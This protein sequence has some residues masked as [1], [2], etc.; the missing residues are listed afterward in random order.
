MDDKKQVLTIK[1]VAEYLGVHPSTIYKYAQTGQIP[2]FKI[3]SD[4]RFKKELIDQWIRETKLV[5]WEDHPAPSAAPTEI[6]KAKEHTSGDIAVIG[7]ACHYP[8]AHN[9]KELWENILAKRVQFRRM[10]DQRL[11]LSEY[12]DENPKT[13]DKMYATKAALLDDFDFDWAKYR[14]PRKTFESTDIVHWLALEVAFKAFEDAGYKLNEIPLENTGVI[15]GNTLTGEQTRSMTLRL[16][17]PYVKKVLDT[18]LESSGMASAD[19]EKLAE[20]MEK[21]FKSAFYPITEDTLAGGLANTIAGRI[22]NYLNFKGGGYLVD[23]ACSS[24][25][26]SV[27]TAANALKNGD[28][29]LALAGGVDIS[30]DPFELVGFS[31]AGA[32]AKDQMKVYDKNAS[33]FIPGEG[34]GFVILKRLEDAVKHRNYIYAVIKGWGISSDGRG[35]IMEPSSGGQAFAMR[36]AYQHAGYKIT[37]CSFIEGHG[38]G[39]AKGDRVELEGIAA[40]IKE[41]A[42]KN[43]PERICGITSFKSMVGHT[44]AA[45]GIGGFLKAVLAVNQRILPP[46]ANCKEPHE[47]FNTTAKSIYP[48]IHGQVLPKNKLIRGGVSSA[49]FGGINCHITLESKDQPKETLKPDLDERLLMSSSQESEVFIFAS[50]TVEHLLKVIAKFKEDIRN[51]S[52]A[53]MADLAARLN[54]NVKAHAPIKIAIVANSP[55]NLYDALKTV[56]KELKSAPPAGRDVHRIKAADPTTHIVLANA[57]KKSR[58]GF[59]YPGQ[60]SQRVNM[61]RMLVERYSWARDLLHTTN[62]I[63][64]DECIYGGNGNVPVNGNMEDLKKRLAQTEITQPAVSFSSLAWSEML[65]RLGIE[66]A[67]VGG[68][69]LGEISAF[70]KA[71]AFDKGTLMRFAEFRGEIMAAESKSPAGMVSLLCSKAQAQKIVS[72]VKGE[73]VIANLNSPAQTVVSG[74]KSEIEEV[75]KLAQ[76]EGI[77]CIPLPVSNAFHSRFMNE[78]SAR[79]KDNEILPQR[80]RLNGVQIYSCVDGHQITETVDLKKYFARQVV[81]P[82]NFIQLVKS[83]SKNCDVLLE[84]GPGRVL[85]DLVRKINKTPDPVCLPVEGSPENDRDL[86][87]V[88]AELFVRGVDIKWNE[89]YVS[90]LV[91]PFIPV[92]RRKFIMNQCEKPLK[93]P[94]RTPRLLSSHYEVHPDE[95]TEDIQEEQEAGQVVPEPASPAASGEVGQILIDI[96]SKMTGFDK[97]T[98]TFD[99]KLLDDLNLDSIKAAEVIAEAAKALGL[100]GE[101]DP[102]QYSN[103]RLAEVR[104][105]LGALRKHKGPVPQEISPAVQL[106]HRESR[107][108]WVRNFVVE[109]RAEELTEKD[110][111]KFSRLKDVVIVMEESG[112][113][114]ATEIKKKFK[115]GQS[116]R[117]ISFN[118]VDDISVPDFHD[119]DGIIFIMPV[120]KRE[121]AFTEDTLRDMIRRLHKAS[122]MATNKSPEKDRTVVFVQFGGG[123]LGEDGKLKNIDSCATR[124]L[125]STLHL[126]HP[127][128]QVRIL[129]FDEKTSDKNVSAKILEEVQSPPDYAIVGFDKQMNRRVPVYQVSEP[130]NYQKR[131]IKWSS[132]DVVLVTG[133]AKGITA[134]CALEF[135][136]ATKARMVLLGRSPLPEEHDKENEIARTLERFRKE[137]LK[138]EYHSCDVTDLA[139]IT[140]LVKKI[141]AKHGKITGFV[142]G[143]GLLTLKRLEHSQMEEAFMDSLPKVVGAMNLCHALEKE[144][145]KMVVGLTSVI[146]VTGME[147]SGWYGV[148]NEILS[149]YLNKF[150]Q[151]HKKADVLTLAYSIWDEVGMGVRTGSVDRLS[152]KGI[153]AIPLNEGV[154]RF[155]HLVENTSGNQQVIITANIAGLDTWLSPKMPDT[156][157]FRF[158]EDIQYVIPGVELVARAHLNVKDDPYL[159]DHN[160]KGSLLFP[161]VFGLE[162]MAQV[163]A[164]LKGQDVV[165]VLRFQNVTLARPI[166]V[167]PDYGTD[168]KIRAVIEEKDKK[169]SSQHIF[170]E[171]YASLDNFARPHFSAKLEMISSLMQEVSGRL[172]IKDKILDINMHGDIFGPI[173]FQGGLFRCIKYA[174]GLYYDQKANS[175]AC[176]LGVECNKSPEKFLKQ[177]KKFNNAISIKD[178]FFIDSMFQSMQMIVTQYACLPNFIQEVRL[179]LAKMDS[180]KSDVTVN[181]QMKKLDQ[182]NLI[183]NAQAYV[184]GSLFIEIKNCRLRILQHLSE[185]PT[186]NDIVNPQDR[187]VELLRQKLSAVSGR[188]NIKAPILGYFYHEGLQRESRKTRRQIELPLV[189]QIVAGVIGDLKKANKI[190][191]KWSRSNKPLIAGRYCDNVR[192]SLSHSGSSL[193]CVGGEAEQGCDIENIE[194]RTQ[195]DW[196]ALLGEKRGSLLREM[197][198]RGWDLDV[199][200]SAIWSAIE[201]FKKAAGKHGVDISLL[202]GDHE[203]FEFNCIS[204][205]LEKHVIAFPIKLTK[206]STKMIAFVASRE[207]EPEGGRLIGEISNKRILEDFGFDARKLFGIDLDYSGPQKQ[208]VFTQRF[209]V[210]FKSSQAPS[211][212][213]YFSNY[214]DWMGMIRE[215]SLYPILK[216][217]SGIASTGEWAMVTNMTDLK[218]LNYATSSDVVEG[219]IWMDDIEGEKSGTLVLSYE[220]RKIK[221]DGNCE[222]IAVSKQKT[223]WVHVEGHG[224]AKLEKMPEF[225]IKYMDLM[226]PKI[227]KI[228]PLINLNEL[229]RD[230]DIGKELSLLSKRHL[231][232][233][234][235]FCEEVIST[236]LED[237]NLLANIYFSNYA[238]WLGKIRDNYFCSFIP[239]YFKNS[240]SAKEMLCLDCKIDYLAEAMPFDKILVRMCVDRAYEFGLDLY[241]EYFLTKD[242]EIIRK[243]GYATQRVLFV[244]WEGGVPMPI[245]IPQ[246]VMGLIKKVVSKR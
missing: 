184:G 239:E 207:G 35:G 17:W 150:Q 235:R 82:V 6:I 194:K 155:R 126:E 214:F 179:E 34:C 68:H 64:L 111:A 29:D 98:I 109:Y 89:L 201:A 51:I 50:R 216:D 137:K 69:S 215:N 120:S 80:Y 173:L 146:G 234:Y 228:N 176:Q 3:G 175:G 22:C 123:E 87:I 211:R 238:K 138:A 40:A 43:V 57:V 209:P 134:E 47:I 1:E 54:Q 204:G 202:E 112:I 91:R 221:P 181:A 147:G 128:M 189:Q 125:A 193:I 101:I 230:I 19:R 12:F 46:T 208:I 245:R 8:G 70:Y 169:G 107:A 220:W 205:S 174:Y 165:E 241:F 131:S 100:A 161:L 60:A 223:S 130:V 39:T 44:K 213:V 246:E 75:T 133:G 197:I 240:D 4:W 94:V 76:K 116:V 56:E 199:S 182:S 190:K 23:G 118:E 110:A 139:G 81:S 25:L 180:V 233:E 74:A 225:L 242:L 78:A 170:I 142:H 237:S 172:K 117:I 168:I 206:G 79:I 77:G 129:D 136:R 38:T 222:R 65:S 196:F 7:M 244:A 164:C 66:P 2:A 18:T 53:E 88:L 27:T 185:N 177:S 28:L 141:K 236:T 20:S 143:A 45:A 30:L 145:L 72:R 102:S 121:K 171:I 192:I 92:S 178:P 67:A 149:L 85:T 99:L 114:L 183:G 218:I 157:K 33:G 73:A 42:G 32:L 144:P 61:T 140:A 187:D 162:A 41:S 13:P 152:F 160:W 83:M 151:K 166:S 132:K 31:K 9:I 122:L 24:S 96:I 5:G 231:P 153:Q 188:R 127:Q 119:A 95:M 14:I 186:A 11:P 227:K 103:S 232:G 115:P 71:G 135:A 167:S 224:V 49:G 21:L 59:L 62:K 106:A 55:E 58:I 163:G 156:R 229:Y 148:A 16:R 158:I 154:K 10:L 159:L 195:E 219:R 86:N 36:R 124:A 26:L 90:R 48:L 15:L 198:E 191:L 105:Q 113:E 84:V 217:F 108:T 210:T 63:N 52:I 212:S 93:D 200:G 97:E 203:S 104:D 37:D 226:R 243:L